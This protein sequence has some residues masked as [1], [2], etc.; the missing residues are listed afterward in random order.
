MNTRPLN[1]QESKNLAALNRAGCNSVL[2]F[3]TETGLHKA[4]LD[5]TEPMRKL[6]RDAGVHDFST[7]AQGP[8]N[9]AVKEARILTDNEFKTVSVSLY[10][11]VTK[12]GDPRLWFYEFKRYASS[13]DVFAV[14]THSKAIYA[15]NLTRSSIA[16]S[17]AA[18]LDNPVTKFLRQITSTSSAISDELL[19]LLK[20]IAKAGPIKAEC[21]GDT[22]V[23]RSIESAL[24][25]RINSSRNPDF[26]GIEIKSGRSSIL[27]SKENR[28]TLFACVPDWDLSALKS[29]RAIL[30]TFG[31]ERGS[32]LKLYCTVTTQRANSQGL[33]FEVKEAE[34]WLREFYAREPVREIC[35]WRLDRLHGRLS[36]KHRE[37]FWVKAKS[38]QRGGNEWFQLESATHTTR[39]SLNQFDR[40]LTDGTVTMDHLIKRKA[41]GRV[42]E[43]GPLFK[44]DRPRLG[45]LFLG[46]P[47]SYALLS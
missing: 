20:Q 15:L 9:K 46:E 45:E 30:E 2:L 33:Q 23:G 29:S 47:R 18:D 12:K 36:E 8:D 7:Q 32:D 19:Q 6:L 11:P 44:I 38:I 43:K 21:V 4:I 1:E 35:I 13:N 26:K 39:P 28:A 31:Y 22:A 27:P 14:F 3:V 24:G 34:K 17:I 40:L 5:A 37:T 25:I 42:S 41:D 10:R 16:Q